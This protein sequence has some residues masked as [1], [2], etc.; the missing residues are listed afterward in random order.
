MCKT[1]ALVVI[2]TDCIGSC[3]PNY[4]TITTMTAPHNYKVSDSCLMTSYTHK[5][6]HKY[7]NKN[8]SLFNEMVRISM[9]SVLHILD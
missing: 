8:K 7:H 6:H 2:G 1:D 4:H 3:Q 9:P 5:L